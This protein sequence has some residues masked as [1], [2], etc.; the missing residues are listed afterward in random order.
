MAHAFRTPSTSRILHER[1]R[2]ERGWAHIGRLLS[3]CDIL[4]SMTKALKE[5]IEVLES[6]PEAEQEVAARAI[7]GF[8]SQLDLEL[9]I[10][11]VGLR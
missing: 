8:A 6:L 10:E 11:G 5:A 9:S 4:C 2:A 1:K 7:L 3:D